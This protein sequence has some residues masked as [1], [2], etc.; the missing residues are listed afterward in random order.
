MHLNNRPVVRRQQHLGF[1]DQL[2]GAAI[3]IGS[4]VVDR[5]IQKKNFAIE[6]QRA[7]LERRRQ[8]L[9][10]TKLENQRR[11]AEAQLQREQMAMGPMQQMI[12][13]VA[14]TLSRPV[15]IPGI[16]SVNMSTLLIAGGVLATVLL[17]RGRK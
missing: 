11:I 16:G 1:W 10:L 3:S 14:Q 15:Q 8:E 13:P 4:K 6:Q 9:E 12:A 7:E 2:V 17:L 5:N